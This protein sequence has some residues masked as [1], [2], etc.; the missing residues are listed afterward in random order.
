MISA[1]ARR[2]VGAEMVEGAQISISQLV[3]T[4]VHSLELRETQIHH[5]HLL[6]LSLQGSVDTFAS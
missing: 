2:G 1:P 4:K 3:L 5:L 6:L